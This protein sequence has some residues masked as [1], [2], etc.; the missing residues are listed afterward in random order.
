VFQN[1]V[2]LGDFENLTTLYIYDP[3]ALECD[4]SCKGGCKFAGPI[5]CH[6]CRPGWKFDSVKGCEGRTIVLDVFL[7]G[8]CA[9]VDECEEDPCQEDGH[10]KCVNSP[11]SFEC[12]CVEGF[13]KEDGKCVVDVIGEYWFLLL[14]AP[15]PA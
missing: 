7:I 6:D 1:D 12:V 4:D 15:L 10:E 9:D 11:G 14:G 8:L 13:K 5:G 3:I 2:L